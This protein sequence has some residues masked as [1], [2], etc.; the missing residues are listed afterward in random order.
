MKFSI[1]RISNFF[2]KPC[3]EAKKAYGNY[4]KRNYRTIKEAKNDY[5]EEEIIIERRDSNWVS[6]YS[7]KKKP[8]WIIE[9]N[10]LEELLKFLN[11]YGRI[12]ICGSNYRQTQYE[13]EIYD[14]YRE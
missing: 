5:G 8:Y 10:T 3:S 9:I 4:F 6:V 14:T 2:G 1:H 12:V 7:K 11:K 13:I